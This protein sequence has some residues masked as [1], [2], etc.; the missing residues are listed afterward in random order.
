MSPP[1]T[2]CRL[3][4]VGREVGPALIFWRASS[5]RRKPPHPRCHKATCHDS[6]AHTVSCIHALT[7]TQPRAMGNANTSLVTQ[8][9][10]STCC[11]VVEPQSAFPR[12]NRGINSTKP[13]GLAIDDL[14]WSEV[15]QEF[16]PLAR[17]LNAGFCTALLL[18]ITIIGVFVGLGASGV[19][20]Q[21]NDEGPSM[22]LI[23]VWAAI[24]LYLG[25]IIYI[26][27]VQNRRVDNQIKILIEGWKH[28]FE[29]AGYSITYL[30]KH[31]GM[32]KPKHAR[33]ERVLAFVPI[34]S[35]TSASANDTIGT[36]ASTTFANTDAEASL[37]SKEH[38][39]SHD[40]RSA[41]AGSSNIDLEMNTG[42][43]STTQELSLVDQLQQDDKLYR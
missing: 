14:L 4:S 22:F 41:A 2:S 43:K 20:K 37:A 6:G 40:T 42:L 21:Y 27:E 25:A 1:F 36:T 35:A 8:T 3:S 23:V 15:A 33:S 18:Y 13:Q 30:T 38:A 10:A 12:G 32:C 9:S 31:T 39:F 5:R 11:L 34:E 17:R 7:I 28:R 24:P 26:Y 16:D 19:I 29:N